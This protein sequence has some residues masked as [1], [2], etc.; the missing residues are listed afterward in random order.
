MKTIICGPPHSGK[1][2]FISNLVKLL[3]SGYYVRINAN[4]DGEGTWSNNPDQDDV[5]G[6]RIKGTNSDEDFQHWKH[7]I[8]YAHKDI[9]IIDIGGRLQEDK[10]P[11]FDV[12][13][14]FI[15]VSNSEEMIGKWIQFGTSH[16]CTCIGTIFSKFG[17]LHESIISKEPYVH[18]VMS[19]LER[20]HNIEGSQL[21]NA[22]ADS[23]IDKSE[24]KGYEKK[25]GTNVIDMYDIGIKLGMSHSR[26]TNKGTAVHS[27]WYQPEKADLLYD[28]MKEFYAGEQKYQIYGARSLWASCLVASCLAENGTEEIDVYG[29]TS[30]RYISV[31]KIG[32]GQS[33]S[34]LLSFSI[35]EN[36]EYVL[37]SVTLPSL[38]TPK[39]CEDILLP[40]LNANKKLLLSGR[41]PSWFAVSIILSYGN[42]EKYIHVPGIGYIKI[43]DRKTHKHGEIITLTGNFG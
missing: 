20:G 11:L 17:E 16:G 22:L 18:G 36:D 9:V 14:S 35:K 15:V 12:S 2:V 4:G 13:D 29:H 1:S 25:G 26:R 6:V 10:A 37:L 21:L 43:A 23:I 39:D 42:D 3:P 41:I 7:Q 19:G 31:P 5:M 40:P 27:V 28:Y 34:K 30:D 32:M 24:F 8:E 38:F 33:K